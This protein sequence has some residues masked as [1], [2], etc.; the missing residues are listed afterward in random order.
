MSIPNINLWK[1]SAISE[2]NNFLSRNTWVPIKKSKVKSKGINP[3]PVNFLF[4]SKEETDELIRLNSRNVV[5]WY[6]Q[7]PGFDYTESFSP[8]DTYTPTIILI[9]LTLFHKE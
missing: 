9:G 6:M 3:V 7:V 8:V 4:K 5:K 1:M 2:V